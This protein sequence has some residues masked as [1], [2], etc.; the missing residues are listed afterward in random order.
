[1]PKFQV[2]AF[3]LCVFSEVAELLGQGRI[4]D[5]YEG[6]SSCINACENFEAMPT[7]HKNTPIRVCILQL[8]ISRSRKFHKGEQ[9]HKSVS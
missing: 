2:E 4:Q 5:F 9:K 6:G 1:M 3:S 7:S 8:Q